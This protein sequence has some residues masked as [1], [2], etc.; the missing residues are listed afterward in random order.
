MRLNFFYCTV[1]MNCHSGQIDVVHDT[2]QLIR[3]LYTEK[4][5]RL[6]RSCLIPMWNAKKLYLTDH[7]M[8]YLLL[9]ILIVIVHYH[10]SAWIRLSPAAVFL[11]N[12][13]S[14]KYQDVYMFLQNYLSTE[15]WEEN[16]Q[17]QNITSS[18]GDVEILRSISSTSYVN[19]LIFFL[20]WASKP[21]DSEEG[22]T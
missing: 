16:Q 18:H 14:R 8:C 15:D 3:N 9:K 20:A 17:I 10:T 5:F 21:W 22:Y 2:I 12:H 1:T 7:F 4:H 13:H 6:Y 11:L 19:F